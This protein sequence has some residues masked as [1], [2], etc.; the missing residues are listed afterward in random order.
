MKA[1]KL[2][3]V[4][5]DVKGEIKYDPPCDDILSDPLTDAVCLFIHGYNCDPIASQRAFDQ[6]SHQWRIAEIKK[7]SRCALIQLNW[8]SHG[9]VF[10]YFSD[11]ERAKAAAPKVADIAWRIH[12]ARKVVH[13]VTHSMG[14]YLLSYALRYLKS[15][16]IINRV[17]LMAP[18]IARHKMNATDPALGSLMQERVEQCRLYYSP[19]DEALGLSSIINSLMEGRQMTERLGECGLPDYS[20]ANVDA[21][22]AEELGGTPFRHTDYL[23]NPSMIASVHS[24]ITRGM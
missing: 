11:K 12:L 22:N 15:T 14:G 6:F 8:P 10:E 20:P 4:S 3:R 2:A 23:S 13:V 19:S 18:D 24:F 21:M 9:N 5:V 7:R 1:T 17:A 16:S